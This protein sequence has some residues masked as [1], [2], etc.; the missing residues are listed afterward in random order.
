MDVHSP[1][2]CSVHVTD[3]KDHLPNVLQHQLETVVPRTEFARVLILR[4][5]HRQAADPGPC[6]CFAPAEMSVSSITAG[7]RPFAGSLVD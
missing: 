2:A 5:S 7:E 6:L 1:T 4:G 3:S